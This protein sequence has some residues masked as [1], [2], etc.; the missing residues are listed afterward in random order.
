MRYYLRLEKETNLSVSTDTGAKSK[1]TQWHP[2]FYSAMQLEFR[3][4]RD[5]L[6]FHIEKVL[7]TKP[8]VMDLLILKV[9]DG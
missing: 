4:N 1:K 2:A 7:N 9:R 3:E 8:L 5:D 6:E